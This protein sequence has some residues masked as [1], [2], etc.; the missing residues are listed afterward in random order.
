M[1]EIWKDIERY[2][3]YYQISTN[4]RIKSNRGNVKLLKPWKWGNY[5]AIGITKNKKLTK[6]YIHR[7][8]AQ[9]FIPNP[10]NK[11]YVNHI[12]GVKN[13]NRLENLEWVTQQENIIHSLKLNLK[14]RNLVLEEINRIKN[15]NTFT[16]IDE[17]VNYLEGPKS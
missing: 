3:E 16:L 13:D 15:E 2:E 14:Y 9:A 4:G 5:L 8:L 7:L 1:Q 10:N 12:N 17:L 6:F 11:L